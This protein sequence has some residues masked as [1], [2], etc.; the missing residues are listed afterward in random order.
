MLGSNLSSFI[1][2]LN[3]EKYATTLITHM[4]LGCRGRILKKPQR[5][6]PSRTETPPNWGPPIHN[7]LCSRSGEDPS[8]WKH[9]GP[10]PTRAIEPRHRP[11]GQ[12]WILGAGL[13]GVR[14]GPLLAHAEGVL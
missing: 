3:L 1:L 7:G 12:R 6:G 11:P 2:V 5:H 10:E 13:R 8:A 14:V 9:F 4:N